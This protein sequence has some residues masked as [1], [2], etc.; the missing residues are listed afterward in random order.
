MPALAQRITHNLTYCQTLR[1]YQISIPG[2]ALS[3]QH[4]TAIDQWVNAHQDELI[5]LVETLIRFPSVNRAPEGDE[6]DAQKFVAAK[7]R[8]M[9]L[10][11]DTFLPTDVP[12]LATHP[13]LWQGRDYT[14]RPNVV[15]TWQGQNPQTNKSLLFSS[16]IDVVAGSNGGRFAPFE[17]TCEDGKLYGRGSNDM[18]G[19][20]AA[21]L[22]AVQCLQALGIRVNGNVIIES[23]VDEEQG[24]SNGTLSS[25]LRG[26]NADA[27]IVPEP[28]A[29]L[30]SPAHKGGR[31]WE[32][33]LQGSPGMPF[34]SDTLINPV[35]GIARLVTA[36]ED[37]S[38]IRNR[39]TAPPPLFR[40]APG[41]PVL[42]TKVIAGE[43]EP[44]AG[45]AV[46]ASAMMEIWVE[47][48][49]GTSEAEHYTRVIE[50]LQTFARQHPSIAKCEM[51][52]RPVTR[53]LPGSEIPPD[54][55]IVQTVSRAFTDTTQ[56]PAEIRGAPFA[57]D[58]FVFNQIANIP[59]V[60]LGP[61]GG[62]AH[63]YDE[64]VLTDDLITLT[65]IFARTIIA[66]CGIAS[67][68]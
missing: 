3:N 39:V 56:Q 62:N 19:G 11:V 33:T 31:I 2:A 22:M 63:S 66:W 29:M 55:P 32:I 25:R 23:V 45:D 52:V 15:G 10:N 8:G 27:C 50:Y 16:H 41:L 53:F 38:D 13:A 6:A 5:Q 37:W 58:V 60:I 67:N 65:K 44:G 42:V 46:P 36:L 61:H 26:H 68:V 48:Y 12:A 30:V 40:D 20:F 43:F 1:N 4:E 7:M 21:T 35:Y 9:N 54:H 24:G 57:C 17:P 49:P 64:W 28:N 51:S 34:G 14:N 59:C 18:K 47:E